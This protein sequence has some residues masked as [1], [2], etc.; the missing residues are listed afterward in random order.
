MKD[1]VLAVKDLIKTNWSKANTSI[2][3][4]PSIHTGWHDKEANTPQVTVSHP[5]EG[6]IH[7]GDTGFTG[8]DPD[9][10]GPTQDI[11][12]MMQVNCWS[13]REVE[14]DVNPK[15]LTF[16]FSEEVKRIIKA[17]TLTVTD[18]RFVS[19]D[20]RRSMVEPRAEPAVFRYRVRVRYG[21]EER[22]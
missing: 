22:P 3:Y 4:D 8:F 21:Y 7:G 12:G 15:K 19:Y 9:G 2:S 20:G 14:V 10:S 13:S 5:D 17:N 16:E 1:P 18:L 6:V 11:N